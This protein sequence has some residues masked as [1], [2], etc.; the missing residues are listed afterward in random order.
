MTDS[1]LGVWL[2]RACYLENVETG[3]R[4]EPFGANPKGVFIFHPDGRAVVVITPAEQTKPVTEADQAEAFQKLLAYSGI[5]RVEPPDRLVIAVDIA[6][7]EPWVGSEQARRFV[8]K[9]DTLEIVG[10]PTKMPLTGDA[11][12]I[13]VLS[14]VREKP[15]K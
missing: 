12:I 4:I 9:G 2:L 13:G 3:E 1:V 14:W 8:V 15:T 11:T 6:W 7:F 5:Y 10:E